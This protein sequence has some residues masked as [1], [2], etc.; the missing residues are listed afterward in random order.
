VFA[1]ES[2]GGRYG[3]AFVTYFNE[4]NEL[5]DQGKISGIKVKFSALLI[6]E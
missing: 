2:Y 5:I 4:Q 6:N 3:P 1:T